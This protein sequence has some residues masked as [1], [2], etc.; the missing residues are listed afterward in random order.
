MPRPTVPQLS[1][2]LAIAALTAV[3][4]LAIVAGGLGSQAALTMGFIPLRLWA[5]VDVPGALPVWLTPL[6]A[7]LVHAGVVH[8]ALNLVMLVFAGQQVERALGWRA[9]LLL[10]LV[11]AYVA[12]GAQALQALWLGGAEVTMVGASGAISAWVGAYALLYGRPR[13]KAL[14]P[15]S[16]QIVH[17]VW[18]AVA[19]AVINFGVGLM[20]S[21]G[22]TPIAVGAHV[23]GFLAGLALARPLLLWRWR[24]A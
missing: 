15:V 19:W 6:S 2:T 1:A 12:A 14:G 18:L 13:A 22:G 23:G 17:V 24:K 9:T 11:G 21:A 8:L 7:T 16:A 10:Y 3:V 5:S 4:S 20:S